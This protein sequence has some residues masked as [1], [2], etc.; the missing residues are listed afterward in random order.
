M[1]IIQ[2]HLRKNIWIVFISFS[3]VIISISDTLNA[4]FFVFL[5]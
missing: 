5:A 4:K 2:V 1:I 3:T